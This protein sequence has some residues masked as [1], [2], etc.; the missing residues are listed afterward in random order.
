MKKVHIV[1]LL[2]IVLFSATI[3][4][5][6]NEFYSEAPIVFENGIKK[7]TQVTVNFNQKVFDIPSRVPICFSSR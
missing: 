6:Q 1:F 2:S 4:N 5:S 7:S 3:L